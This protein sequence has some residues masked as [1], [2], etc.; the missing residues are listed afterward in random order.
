MTISKPYTLEI[1]NIRKKHRN[2][3]IS[4]M[5]GYLKTKRIRCGFVHIK[6]NTVFQD[7]IF[8]W[9][10]KFSNMLQRTPEL[11]SKAEYLFLF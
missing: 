1:D 5:P 3:I 9:H 4:K 8:F 7:Q 10:F 6:E 2:T 11:K